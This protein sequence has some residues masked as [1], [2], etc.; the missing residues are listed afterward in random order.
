MKILYGIAATGNGHISRSRII[1]D[2]LRKK[3]HLVD[4]ILS[5]RDEKDLF[6]IDDL[7]PFKVKRGFTFVTK[8]GKIRYIK[9]LL[10]SKI[11]EFFKDIKSI[12]NKYDLVITDLEPISAYAA[13]LYKIPSM[14]IGHQYSFYKNIPMKMNMKFASVF[15]PKMYSPVDFSIPF[16]FNHFNQSILPPIIDPIFYEEGNDNQCNEDIL[17][18]LAWENLNSIISVFEK[19]SNNFIIYTNTESIKKCGNITLKPFSNIPFKKDL[20]KCSGLITNGGFELPS[21][22]LFLGKPM[23]CKPLGGQPEQQH[24]VEILQE[25]KYATICNKI[26]IHNVENWIKNKINVRIPFKSPI[27]LIID[28][29]ENPNMDFSSKVMELWDK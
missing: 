29:I 11:I 2:V 25:L 3:G 8:K 17:V 28:I 19:I 12:D 1:V 20:I 18:Y 15:I 13:K 7:K 4:V 16:H 23:L 10:E 14:G 21:E 6:D 26:D 24:N 9:T 27:N 22:A 5:G